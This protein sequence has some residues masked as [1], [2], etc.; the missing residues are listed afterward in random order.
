MAPN[1]SEA[2]VL[3]ILPGIVGTIQAA[4]AIKAILGVEEVL[5]GKLL[6]IDSL[7]MITRVLSFDSP[8]RASR[9]GR[10]NWVRKDAPVIRA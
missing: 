6:T 7:T 4:E 1:C 8:G 10:K 2:G 9:K 5:R 3:G